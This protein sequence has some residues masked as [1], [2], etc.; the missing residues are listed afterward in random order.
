MTSAL[1]HSIKARTPR[2]LHAA[3]VK[4][5]GT[6]RTLHAAIVKMAGTPRARH[7]AIA[8]VAGMVMQ[9][10]WSYRQW[11]CDVQAAIVKVAGI[12][13]ALHAA[14]V[15]ACSRREAGRNSQDSEL[16]KCSHDRHWPSD[17]HAAIVSAAS[18]FAEPGF[19]LNRMGIGHG[20]LLPLVFRVS[21]NGSIAIDLSMLWSSR[22]SGSIAALLHGSV[23][24]NGQF[25]W[26]HCG[27]VRGNAAS[28]FRQ[29]CIELPSKFRQ[30]AGELPAASKFRQC[31]FELPSAVL[32]HTLLNLSAR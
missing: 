28:K 30:D 11:P 23:S 8:K 17:G 4:M 12:P 25:S 16:Q 15:S 1:L 2:T 24:A 31:C 5:A 19:T 7:A 20:S 18:N 26:L 9:L 27:Q 22:W 6:P 32:H 13:R 14:I 3:I 10:S 29:C 21:I